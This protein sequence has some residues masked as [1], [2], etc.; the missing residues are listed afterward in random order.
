MSWKAILEDRVRLGGLKES[1]LTVYVSSGELFED[2]LRSKLGLSFDV[3]INGNS[4][5]ASNLVREYV[6]DY[7]R[8]ASESYRQSALKH[9]CA[10]FRLCGR[11]LLDVPRIAHF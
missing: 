5:T 10:V 9:L 11:P 8:S 7:F 6:N 2:W 1:T 3:V 4:Q